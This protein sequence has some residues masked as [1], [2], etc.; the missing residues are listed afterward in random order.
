MAYFVHTEIVNFLPCK[1]EKS[2]DQF[3]KLITL[4]SSHQHKTVENKW[5]TANFT[6]FEHFQ[7]YKD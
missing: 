6:I 4:E 5:K 1:S 3:I 2:T 7:N